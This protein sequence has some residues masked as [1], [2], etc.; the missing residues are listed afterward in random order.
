M[1]LQAITAAI[2]SRET[3]NTRVFKNAEI[4]DLNGSL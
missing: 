4:P 2:G 3:D 1:K